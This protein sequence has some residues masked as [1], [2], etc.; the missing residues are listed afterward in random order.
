M[1]SLIVYYGL[2]PTIMDAISATIVAGGRAQIRLTAQVL[3]TVMTVHL[4]TSFVALWFLAKFL[5][6]HGV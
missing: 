1:I 4:K 3:W 5:S 6:V 2:P